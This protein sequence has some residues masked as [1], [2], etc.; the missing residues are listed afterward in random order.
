MKILLTGATGYI[1]KRLL[2]ELIY[3]GHHIVCTVRDKNRFSAPASILN[4]IEVI[5]VDFL[6]FKSLEKI[7][8]D[9]E[10][11]YY[12]MHSMSNTHDYEKLEKQSAIHF[13]EIMKGKD[14]RHVVYLSGITNEDSLSAHLSSR[15]TVEHELGLGS[16]P[17]T[18][19]RAGIIIGS[20]SASFEIIRDLVEKLPLMITPKWLDTKCQPIGVD[21]VL[22]CL[23]KTLGNE[24]TYDQNFDHWRT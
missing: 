3:H 13:R 19:L 14:V 17:L 21:N 16:Y 1:G 9:I 7:P 4:Q 6:D 10:G 15:R 8:Q 20:G 24:K 12:L 22:D 23:V 5:E 11:A 18:T 2:L